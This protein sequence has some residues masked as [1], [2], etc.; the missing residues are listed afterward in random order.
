LANYLLEHYGN[1]AYSIT[2]QMVEQ[3]RIGQA[4]KPLLATL[5]DVGKWL[6]CALAI[7]LV[8]WWIVRRSSRTLV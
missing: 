6:A 3:V 8:L 5:V 2:P 1:A 4:P 7:S